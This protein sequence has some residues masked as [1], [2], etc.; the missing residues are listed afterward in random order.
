MYVLDGKEAGGAVDK[1]FKA[2]AY[3]ADGE[4]IVLV[5]A[6]RPDACIFWFLVEDGT[7]RGIDVIYLV[8]KDRSGK[9]KASEIIRW[10]GVNIVGVEEKEG[11][12]LFKVSS[13]DLLSGV[14]KIPLSKLD[15]EETEN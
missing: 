8:W 1:L 12:F 9:V 2:S 7:V 14:L 5:V 3:A 13:G 15:L 11:N 6:N 10:A 4:P